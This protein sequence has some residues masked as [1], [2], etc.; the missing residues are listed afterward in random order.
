MKNSLL[1]ICIILGVWSC[2][3]PN[4]GIVI[5]VGNDLDFVRQNEVVLVTDNMMDLP[6]GDD[7]SD[8]G[9]ANDKGELQLIQYS[10]QNQDGNIDAILFLPSVSAVSRVNYFL[11]KLKQNQANPYSENLCFSRFVPERTDDY[12]WENDR[13]AFRMFGPTA[14]KMNEEGIPG[15]TLTSGVD[16]WLKKVEY[17][18]ID[19]W[20][21]GY[22]SDP[23]Y[24]HQDR[25]E[26][27]DNF[28]V[29]SSRGCGG[30]AYL[31]ENIYYSPKNYTS[32]NTLDN[33]FMRTAFE[34]DYA[35]WKA[36][37]LTIKTSNKVSLDRGSHLSKMVIDVEG[38]ETL[39]AGLTLHENDGIVT[40]DPSAGWITYWQPHGDSYL[41]TAIVADPSVFKGYEKVESEERDQSN[42]YVTL[43]AKNGQVTYY[44]GFFW[45]EGKQF[46]GVENWKEYLQQFA[47]QIQSPLTVSIN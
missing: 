38:S 25:G 9:I 33:G 6:E 1:I 47:Q 27:L 30:I 18:I 28:H 43:A 29:G 24:Y 42:A 46:E 45:A 35:T 12:T 39:Q 7:I 21:K 19:N 26:G 36:G 31:S 23:N 13:V 14:Q 41:G 8:Y 15:G 20:Y 40:A 32:Y 4:K 34:L 44:T 5:E 11:I 3:T 37:D 2:S 10:D 22:E 17:S 16:C